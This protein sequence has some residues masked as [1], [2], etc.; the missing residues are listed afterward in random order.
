M[1]HEY[2][3]WLWE[4][5]RVEGAFDYG[6]PGQFQRGVQLYGEFVK[7]RWTRSQPV[8]VWL[9]KLF[10]GVRAMLTH[11]EARVEYGRILRE[12]SPLDSAG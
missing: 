9:T 12:E 8:N 11:L 10:F 1:M 4:P 7:R 3:E 2:C 5:L 6:T